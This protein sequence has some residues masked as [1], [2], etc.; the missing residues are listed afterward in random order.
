MPAPTPYL[1]FDRVAAEALRFYQGV[2]GGE[3]VLDT[4]AEFG[5]EDG[6]EDAIAHGVLSGAVDLFGADVSGDER[7][8][9][10]EGVM[11][12]LL[13]SATPDVLEGWFAALSDGGH[14]LDALQERPW[15]D[16]DG[17]VRDRFGVTWLLG[18]E[19]GATHP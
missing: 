19:G 13:G 11:L 7:P 1:L 12:S 2:F 5:R 16:V 18:H 3:L 9:R 8:I 4:F 15:G 6:P 17:T 14:V 10:I